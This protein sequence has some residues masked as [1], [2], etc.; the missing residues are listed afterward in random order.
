MSKNI[1]LCL[2]ACILLSTISSDLY[3]Q[4]E[5]DSTPLVSDLVEASEKLLGLEFTAEE[6]D[7][8]LEDLAYNLSGYHDL[9]S[10][11]LS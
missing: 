9:E 11:F 5:N 2:A 4:S 8:A 1:C 7:S 10:Y 6:R 3:S